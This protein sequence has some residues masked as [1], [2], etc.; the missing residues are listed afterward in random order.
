MGTMKSRMGRFFDDLGLTEYQKAVRDAAR[1][2]RPLPPRPPEVH[3]YRTCRDEFCDEEA[4]RAYREGLE[5][6]RDD[7]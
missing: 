1:E 7:Y 4:C 5:D 6:G 3:K 2:G